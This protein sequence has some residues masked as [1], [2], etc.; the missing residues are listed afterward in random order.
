VNGFL[1]RVS[2]AVAGKAHAESHVKTLETLFAAALHR[3]VAERLLDHLAQE[4]VGAL[5]DGG[6]DWSWLADHLS[7]WQ[8]VRYVSATAGRGA[9]QVVAEL[10]GDDF[11]VWFGDDMPLNFG[12]DAAVAADR[13]IRGVRVME[14]QMGDV[15]FRFYVDGE[16]A[17][18]VPDYPDVAG[19]Q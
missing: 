6:V 11:V 9:G 17:L 1:R 16:V 4:R 15:D 3:K 18:T 2:S 7:M 8:G 19:L 14:R 10:L 5:G 13:F 12:Q